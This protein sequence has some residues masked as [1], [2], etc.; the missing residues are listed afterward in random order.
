[1]HQSFWASSGSGLDGARYV[2]GYRQKFLV[3]AFTI[4][5]VTQPVTSSRRRVQRCE[6]SS[7]SSSSDGTTFTKA[8]IPSRKCCLTLQITKYVPGSEKETDSCRL[9]PLKGLVVAGV[10]SGP[11]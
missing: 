3:L 1:M 10:L 11:P 4:S 5:A 6:W 7:V 2:L 8:N 9:E